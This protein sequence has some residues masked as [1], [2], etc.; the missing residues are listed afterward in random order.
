MHLVNICIK[1]QQMHQL[2]IQLINYVW[3]LLHV[4]TLRCHLK[5]AFLVPSERC[6]I[7]EQS[8]EYWAFVSSD[9]V[10]GDLRL[11][12][13][14]SLEGVRSGAVGEALCSKPEGCRFASW[15]CHWIFL[16]YNPSGC[17]MALGS[18]QPLTEMSTRNITWGEGGR[19]VG[20]TTLLPSCADCLKIWE[21]QPLG[22]LR[23]CH[24]L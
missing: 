16:W 13:T 7:E 11:P 14:M 22:T 6:S 18:T 20:L 4:S 12:H 23:D 2:F 10:C 15:R 24:G 9:M 8:I 19:C 21:P 17:T 1:N 3:Y 5:G